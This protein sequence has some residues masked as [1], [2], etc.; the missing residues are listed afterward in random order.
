METTSGSLTSDLKSS[1]GSDPLSTSGLPRERRR[2]RSGSRN[3]QESM[4]YGAVHEI[5]QAC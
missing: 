1:F 4:V 3:R 2:S 5:S